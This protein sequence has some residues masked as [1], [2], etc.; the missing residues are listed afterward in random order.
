[1]TEERPEAPPAAAGGLMARIGRATREAIAAAVAEALR[2]TPPV[3]A[4][5]WAEEARYLAPGTT[6]FPGKWRN[7]LVPYLI[8]PMECISLSH[9][10]RRVVMKKSA[11]VA[12]TEAVINLFGAVACR[13]PTGM[14]VVH[15]SQ[16][17]LI[18]F[19]KLKLWPQIEATPEL[20]GRVLE[21]KRADEKGST[22]SLQVFRG[23]WCQHITASSSK[24]LQTI[25]P[26]IV[27][28]EEPAEY[29][30]EAGDRGDVF[31]QAEARAK[32]YGESAKFV[33]GGTPG[34]EGACE[35]TRLY[36]NESDQ[37]QYFVPCPHCGAH[38]TLEWERLDWTEDRRPYGAFFICA[39]PGCGGV[40]EHRHRELMVAR[41]NWIKTY[42][43]PGQP[44]PVFE[45]RHLAEFRAR[46]SGGF[47][48]G[49]SIWEAY[50][51]FRTWDLIV[52]D[53]LKAE[54]Q[55][56][57]L[58]SF[59]QQS[60]GRAWKAAG[61]AQDD[62]KLWLIREAHKHPSRKVPAGVLLIV[63][64]FDVQGNR[65]EGDFWGFDAALGMHHIEALVI[66]GNTAQ[67]EVWHKLD[68]IL[69]AARW[70]DAQGRIWGYDAIGIDQSYLTNV[71]CGWAMRHAGTGKVFALD[72][73]P[74]WGRPPLGVPKVRDIDFDGRKVGA[75]KV[76][77]VGTFE[78]KS[79]VHAAMA[80]A[81]Q[82][83]DAETGR[84]ALGA[85][86]FSDQ[87]DR[88][89]IG[90]LTSEYLQTVDPRTGRPTREWVH[91]RRRRNERFDTAVYARA[92]AHH[93]TDALTPADWRQLAANRAA[94]PAASQKDMERLWGP[95]L[96]AVPQPANAVR[97]KDAAADWLPP[98]EDWLK[99]D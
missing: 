16:A 92:L 17:A 10:A 14:I 45:E 8:E 48:P 2:P 29:G 25:S 74:G 84:L 12:W 26:Q 79:E 87:V 90:Q 40:I 33:Y 56:M 61:D 65:I 22:T 98:A 43:G 83:A 72:G 81:L 11:Q 49:F 44:P 38:Q 1:M 39:A 95:A 86:R 85:M 70:P 6:R 94:E 27:I 30:I 46:S 51:P 37:R 67:P 7:A 62:E 77:P 13:T 82:G 60:L 3:T 9:P 41:G 71:V 78:L 99:K 50:S 68:E 47:D 76:W 19:V 4:A 42:P 53:Y 5:Q 93:L 54:G 64:G 89:Y 91:D 15:P 20:R 69:R 73:L 80:L 24:E 55:P 96:D 75:V 63:G 28:Y 23:G 57:K 88:D 32:A 18:K 36:E 58:K 34:E 52:E 59:W 66:E 97:P 21:Q 31:T 35:V